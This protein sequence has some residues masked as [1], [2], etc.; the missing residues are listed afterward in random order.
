MFDKLPFSPTNKYKYNSVFSAWR[1]RKRKLAKAK[2]IDIEHLVTQKFWHLMNESL[3]R[4]KNFGAEDIGIVL[5][6]I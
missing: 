4:L 2:N 5:I 6:L 3:L 1:Y